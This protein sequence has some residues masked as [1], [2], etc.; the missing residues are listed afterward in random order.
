MNAL[1]TT[2][3]PRRSTTDAETM[4][5]GPQP[6]PSPSRTV[7]GLGPAD[8]ARVAA[9]I[10][11]AAEPLPQVR[12]ALSGRDLAALAATGQLRG[13]RG[14]WSVYRI[15]FADRAAYVGITSGAVLNRIEQHFGCG[16]RGAGTAA[17]FR[18]LAAGIRCRVRCVASGLTEWQARDLEADRIRRLWRPLN[19]QHVRR[20][21][22]DPLDP[23]PGRGAVARL[24]YGA[25]T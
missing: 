5:R 11:A 1:A 3:T 6:L 10:A 8:A 17:I 13:E 23:D 25:G 22:L 20:Q 19:A 24:R 16:D 12:A 9:L 15:T 4:P 21:W 2:R 7:N 18:R 14:G